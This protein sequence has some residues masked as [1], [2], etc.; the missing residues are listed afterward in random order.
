MAIAYKHFE[1]IQVRVYWEE[2]VVMTYKNSSTT[3][4]LFKGKVLFTD[5]KP[6]QFFSVN[7]KELNDIL[8]GFETLNN[9]KYGRVI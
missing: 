2:D 7:K 4:Q 1:N 6:I 3:T 9:R 8:K 5:D